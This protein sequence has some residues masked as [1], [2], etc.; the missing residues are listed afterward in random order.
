MSLSTE[1]NIQNAPSHIPIIIKRRFHLIYNSSYSPKSVILQKY[2]RTRVKR[3][4]K[5]HTDSQHK[6][7]K[8]T[9]SRNINT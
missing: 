2:H 6:S 1:T 7:K 9:N 5:I 3:L 8:T 4:D